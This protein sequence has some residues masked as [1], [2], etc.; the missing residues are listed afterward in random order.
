MEGYLIVY[1]LKVTIY[2]KNPD[3]LG[4]KLLN[5]GFFAKYLPLA[6]LLNN[7]DNTLTYSKQ[8]HYLYWLLYPALPHANG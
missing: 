7:I 3:L 8:D 6:G 4:V 1:T 2:C 5:F